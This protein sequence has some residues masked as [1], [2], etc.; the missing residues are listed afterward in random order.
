MVSFLKRIGLRPVWLCATLCLLFFQQTTFAEGIK[1]LAPASSD[2][3]MLNCNNGAYYD[4]ARYDGDSSTRLYIHIEHPNKEQVFLGFSQ[5]RSSIYTNSPQVTGWFRIKAPDG[6]V[7]Y[8]AQRIDGTTANINNWSQGNAGPAP[9]AGSG[10]YT[11]FV[12]DPTGLAAGDYYIEFNR[13]SS[14]YNTGVLTFEYFDITVATNGTTPAAINGRVF[15]YN[16]AFAA[17]SNR[18]NATTYGDYHRPFNGTFYVYTDE[19]YVSK[20]DF[21]GSG[22]QPWAFNIS[23]NS[24]GTATGLG[25]VEN[26]KSLQSKQGNIP[27]Y[28][29][30]LND[31]DASIYPSGTF[32][33]L[34]TDSTLLYGCPQSGYF[35]KLVTT[36]TGVVEVLL[37]QDQASGTGVYDPGTAD[38]LL[39]F[40]VEQQL[41]DTIPGIYIRHIPWD[42]LDGLGNAVNLANPVPTKVTFSQGGYHIPVYDAEYNLNGF[43]ATIERP[44]PPVGYSLGF[45]YDDSNIS[46]APT[47]SEVETVGCTPACHTWTDYDFGDLNTINTWWFAKQEN[48]SVNMMVASAVPS[49]SLSGPQSATTI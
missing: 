8:T 19:Q 30:Y 49:P 16:W 21:N 39:A 12:F 4:F 29:V 45:Y 24:T 11:P 5:P 43:T 20:I 35:F 10:G 37:D 41:T 42:G 14:T 34:L 22:F 28:A 7:V 2:T 13:D 15:A 27:E 26:R 33:E 48:Q 25:V 18:L 17:P 38:R 1:E 32:G 23:L 44:S 3:L 47:G 36:K 9:I 40:Y 46:E 31:P 6:T